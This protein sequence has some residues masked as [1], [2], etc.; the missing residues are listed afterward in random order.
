MDEY[1]QL[2]LS[3]AIDVQITDTVR[4]SMRMAGQPGFGPALKAGDEIEDLD[5]PIPGEREDW[6]RRTVLVEQRH[7]D[8]ARLVRA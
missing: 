4:E 2:S 1:D 7:V 5:T 8:A 6:V 3:E